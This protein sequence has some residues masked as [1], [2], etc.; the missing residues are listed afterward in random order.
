MAVNA[1]VFWSSL[2]NRSY[3]LTMAYRAYC[4]NDWAKIFVRV[5]WFYR[6]LAL[7]VGESRL[8]FLLI[9]R[10][11]LDFAWFN[12]KAIG[13]RIRR[14]DNLIIGSSRST[15]LNVNVKFPVHTLQSHENAKRSSPVTKFRIQDQIPKR[16]MLFFFR[17]LLPIT[18]NRSALKFIEIQGKFSMNV[19]QFQPRVRSLR[20]WRTI[21]SEM[22][23]SSSNKLHF[24]ANC[25]RYAVLQS[26]RKRS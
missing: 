19:M 7:S 14:C 12:G 23:D 10:V 17:M 8:S 25:A 22:G 4:P 15:S 26:P 24:V 18:I 6:A 1:A 13:I 2:T 16:S 3:P 11:S 9:A 5:T 20:N 21:A